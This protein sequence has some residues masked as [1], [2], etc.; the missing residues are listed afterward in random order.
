M[1][2]LGFHL[3]RNSGSIFK[4]SNP[5]IFKLKFHFINIVNIYRPEITVNIDYYRNGNSSFG[6]GNGNYDKG[7]EMA[8]QVLWIQIFIER[9]KVNIHGI[10]NQLN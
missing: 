9:Y 5:Q 10:E 2:V 4:F 8:L 3:G 6:G 1:I 7:E